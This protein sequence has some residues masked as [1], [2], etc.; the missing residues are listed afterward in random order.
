[1][2]HCKFAIRD[3]LTP[4]PEAVTVCATVDEFGHEQVVTE[5]MI[6][7]A[8]EQIDDDQLWPVSEACKVAEY[9]LRRLLL[10]NARKRLVAEVFD[11]NLRVRQADS[12]RISVTI[13]RAR[14]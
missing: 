11:D 13:C 1:M 6:S 4:L 5:L 3:T 9:N 8:C 7:Q 10:A 12:F 14:W 2:K